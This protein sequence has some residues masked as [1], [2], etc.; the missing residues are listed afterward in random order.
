MS[1]NLLHLRPKTPERFLEL[2]GGSP[3]VTKGPLD[4]F[5]LFYHVELISSCS[6]F[7]KK[8]PLCSQGIIYTG[9]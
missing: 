4:S 9:D 5:G 1:Q 3:S 7:P 8:G 2:Q 6:L